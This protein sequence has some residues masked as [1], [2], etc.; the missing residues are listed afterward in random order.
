VNIRV[1]RFGVFK[2]RCDYYEIDLEFMREIV[3]IDYRTPVYVFPI[4]TEEIV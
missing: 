2:I 4:E 3:I 1:N